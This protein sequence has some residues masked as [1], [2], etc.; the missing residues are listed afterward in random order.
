MAITT[1]EEALAA[2]KEDGMALENV[3][4]QYKTA[5]VCLEAVK[6]NGAALQYVPW[7]QL[8][9][10]VPAME[11]ICLEAVMNYNNALEYVPKNLWTAEM[12]FEVIS[13]N[14]IRMANA[15][16][17]R[18]ERDSTI[19]KRRAENA[20]IFEAMPEEMREEVHRML[21]ESGE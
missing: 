5:E 18:G 6:S 4:E 10:T 15:S 1:I 8:N 12:C 9:L 16:N 3:P 19:E 14:R 7:G 11:E 21:K 20:D 2:V 17:F 13:G